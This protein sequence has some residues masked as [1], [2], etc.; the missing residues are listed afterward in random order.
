[1]VRPV[2]TWNLGNR[3]LELGKRTLIMAIVNVTPDSF[4]DGGQFLAPEAA[5][6]Q[7]RKL[8]SHGA[9]V[10]DIGG[11]SSR[12]KAKAG[13]EHPEVGAEEE[14]KRILPVIHELKLSLPSALISVDTTRRRWPRRQSEPGQR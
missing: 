10:V 8:L 3:S 12:P 7:A 2:F 13:Q 4:S 14:L 9:D 6:A 1:M 5:V 11:E